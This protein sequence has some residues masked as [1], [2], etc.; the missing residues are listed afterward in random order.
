VFLALEPRT[1]TVA[2]LSKGRVQSLGLFYKEHALTLLLDVVYTKQ[3]DLLQ[4]GILK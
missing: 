4:A 2:D 3:D 1:E